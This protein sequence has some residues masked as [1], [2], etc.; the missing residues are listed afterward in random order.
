MRYFD[1]LIFY[2]FNNIDLKFK[3]EFYNHST[4]K[5][6]EKIFQNKSFTNLSYT[7]K[8]IPLQTNPILMGSTLITLI[9]N[10]DKL[11]S[12]FESYKSYI[13]KLS[14]ARNSSSNINSYIEDIENYD[15]EDPIYLQIL[16]N[17]KSDI[18][19]IFQKRV[20]ENF[21]KDKDLKKYIVKTD[22]SPLIIAEIHNVEN[23]LFQINENYYYELEKT[24][25]EV[26]QKNDST[27]SKEIAQQY[28]DLKSGLAFKNVLIKFLNNF[29]NELNKIKKLIDKS[30]IKKSNESNTKRFNLN[31]IVLPNSNFAYTYI[32]NKP[33]ITKYVYE[34]TSIRELC[35]I[36][37]Y[38]LLINKKVISKCQ[39]CNDYFIPQIR[40]DEIYCNKF[41][42]YNNWK[43]PVTCKTQGKYN[44]YNHNNRNEKVDKLY[45]TLIN[46]LN[47]R[48][49]NDT[50]DT[51]IYANMLKRLKKV[52]EVTT[53][54]S[55]NDINYNKDKIFHRYLTIFD[56]QFQKKYPRQKKNKYTSN[57]YWYSNN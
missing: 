14:F 54:K 50:N 23:I 39:N 43:E 51:Y 38:Q 5:I 25:K 4:G 17:L 9:N 22:I 21:P 29:I 53:T 45:S 16:Q 10:Y 37:I 40:N 33:T 28:R 8:L 41:Q 19:N 30:F 27:V 49:K 12:L 1:N 32:D 2:K 11:I 46:R 36:T 3:I 57:Q 55:I 24:I 44:R 6:A 31:N 56:K 15:F 35:Y 7:N 42:G 18:E 34:F 20:Y 48:I 52:K 47:R 13:S 26:A